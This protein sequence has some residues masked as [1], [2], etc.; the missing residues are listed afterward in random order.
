[1]SG[2][3]STLLEIIAIEWRHLALLERYMYVNK[4]QMLMIGGISLHAWR[5]IQH[6]AK[7]SQPSETYYLLGL[8]HPTL[9]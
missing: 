5:S 9:L 3:F 2:D 8:R 7:A 6:H 4:E 1:M